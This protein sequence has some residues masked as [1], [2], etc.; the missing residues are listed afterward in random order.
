M[1]AYRIASDRRIA[2]FGDRVRDLYVGTETIAE[3]Q[4]R[5]ASACGLDLTEIERVESATERP[6]LVFMDDVFFTEMALRQFVAEV[7]VEKKDARLAVPESA[8]LRAVTILDDDPM[9]EEGAAAFDIFHLASPDPRETIDDLRAACPPRAIPSDEKKIPIMLPHA[10]GIEA[11]L[12]ARVVARVRHWVHLLRLSQLS[13]GVTLIDRLRKRPGLVLRLRMMRNRDPWAKARKVN[14]VDPTARVHP[15]AD[16]ECAVVGPG[17]IVEAHAHVHRSVI[18]KGV[19]VGDHAVVVGCTLGA[20]V[21]VLRASYFALCASMP[22]AT[23]AS[24]KAQVSLF[25]KSAFL[26]TS[27]WLIDAKL[28]GDVKVEHDGRAV[29][30]RTP[31]LGV[32]L[33]H[34]VT[35]GAQVTILAGRAVPNDSVIVAPPGT[36][37]SAL[38]AY[39]PGTLLCIRNGRVE[40]V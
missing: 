28:Q 1:R 19:H 3:W 37:A 34:R 14:F 21:Q 27:A 23:L 18:G 39:P 13:V 22:E 10:E 31:F 6:C 15:T 35:L 16:L 30:V 9:P 32:C 40:P 29:S 12:S 25:G 38:P 24:Y 20:R 5:A 33:G 26:T 7:M 17:A 2:P 36:F 11:P 4:A 8:V